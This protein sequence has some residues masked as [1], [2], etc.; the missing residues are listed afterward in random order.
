MT[1]PLAA[2]PGAEDFAPR[3]VERAVRTEAL[4]HPL[5]IVPG[6]GALGLAFW[7]A[8]MGLHPATLVAMLGLAFVSGV[9][10][11]Y[12]YLMRG[13][14]HATAH[15]ERLRNLRRQHEAQEVIDLAGDCRRASFIQGAEKVSAL[16]NAFEAFEG[17]VAARGGHAVAH[18]GRDAF[19]EG[20]AA[21]E[22]ALAAY[23]A[24]RQLGHERPDR[25]GALDELRGNGAL[26]PALRDRQRAIDAKR[27]QRRRE[28]DDLVAELLVRATEIEAAIEA[29]AIDLV[30]D[31]GPDAIPIEGG[32]ASRLDMALEAA[33]RVQERARGLGRAPEPE[34]EE[35]L[36][37][38]RRS[39]GTKEE[40]HGR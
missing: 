9:S 6:A 38:G 8:V 18:L 29:A 26:D 16:T 19:R 1:P 35:Y 28:L 2:K 30:T 11:A 32:G 17:R 22:R 36:E 40:R 10:C 33:R 5:T 31:A 23:E 27:A 25:D 37:T 14:D 13:E 24:R 21:V 34:D 7:S 20:L 15:V 4:Q 3:A 39:L 12:Q